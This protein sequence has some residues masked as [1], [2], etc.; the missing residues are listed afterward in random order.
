MAR[1]A[2][3]R[4]RSRLLLALAAGLLALAPA[5]AHAAPA[6][7]PSAAGRPPAGPGAVLFPPAVEI[8]PTN[9]VVV[10]GD[11]YSGRVQAFS[12]SGP[13]LWTLGQRAARHEPGRLGVIG[14]VAVDRSGHLY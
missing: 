11:E 7:T 6:L 14:G 5:A 8:D 3:V 12:P 13:F 2:A 10:V 9:G 4:H 1:S